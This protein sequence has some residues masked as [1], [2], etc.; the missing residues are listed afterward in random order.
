MCCK[1]GPPMVWF[2]SPWR[3]P[4]PRGC[5]GVASYGLRRAVS[6]GWWCS[7]HGWWSIPEAE[8][9]TQ[10]QT[11]AQSTLGTRRT[12]SPSMRDC[13]TIRGMPWCPASRS[14]GG[15]RIGST[16]RNTVPPHG[17]PPAIPERDCP[18]SF[19]TIPRKTVRSGTA[20]FSR[21]RRNKKTPSRNS[22]RSTSPSPRRPRATIR[23]S[24]STSCFTGW[25]AG[26][27]RNTY[28]TWRS[29]ETPRDP[30]SW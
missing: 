5:A 14:D 8:A 18:S 10:T 20:S 28:G 13:T 25:E 21:S 16:T 24:R 19:T 12:T 11:V 4:C 26:A 3:W 7:R 22:W 27:W 6:W 15:R 2:F 30:P 9:E 29:V 1:T 17:C 23:P